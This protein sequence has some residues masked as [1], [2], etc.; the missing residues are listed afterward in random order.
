MK[1]SLFDLHGNNIPKIEN[2]K[3]HPSIN[4][5][6]LAGNEIVVSNHL[7]VPSLCPGFV[8][9]SIVHAEE[10]VFAL[11]WRGFPYAI[12]IGHLVEIGRTLVGL[13]NLTDLKMVGNPLC[14]MRDYRLRVL[15]NLSI[16]MLDDVEVK[17]RLRVYLAEMERRAEL[18][19]IMEATTQDYMDSIA[20][21]REAKNDNMEIL[22]KSQLELEDAFGKYRTEMENELRVY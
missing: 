1:N 21:E 2:L 7:M 16:K 15:E 5:L 17:P 11:R 8:L 4:R 12:T 22:R 18:E 19:D 13:T 20:L 6:D 9:N 14:D 10:L 3:G